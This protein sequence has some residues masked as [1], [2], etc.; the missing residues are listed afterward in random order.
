VHVGLVIYGGLE[1]VS[2]GY[3]YDRRLV[4][5]LRAA[6]DTVTIFSL[7]WRSYPRHLADN[8]RPA[9]RRR[10][11]ALAVDVLI[12]DELNHP[13]L[14]WLNRSLPQP[15]LA[16]IHHLRQSED[17]PSWARWLYRRIERA[18]LRSVDG[19]ICNSATTLATAQAVSGRADLPTRIARPGGDRLQ[20]DLTPA[21]VAARA[22][23]PGPLRLLFVGNLIARKGLHHLIAAVGR[24]P[25]GAIRLT[26]IGNPAAD[27][28]YTRAVQQTAADLNLEPWLD[29]CGDVSDAEL[30]AAY[31]SHQAL[32][33]PSSYEG[34][35][36]VYAEALGFGLPV[37][38][39]AAG[40]P[41]EIITSGQDGALI[42]PGDVTTLAATLAAWHSDRAALSRLAQNALQTYQRHPTWEASMAQ[43]RPFLQ[44]FLVHGAAHA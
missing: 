35:G 21:A 13:S 32:A 1:T 28:T 11:R 15:K 29:F 33:V 19:W 9:L 43:V 10:L 20:P 44:E 40:A 31:R 30:R 36:I 12:E 16:L 39:S 6:G 14:V 8:L 24:L 3:L 34:Y 4:A 38:A 18:Y 37:I 22:A 42:S 25:R 2:G 17:H 23:Q 26:V 7:P 41:R 27:P 5:S